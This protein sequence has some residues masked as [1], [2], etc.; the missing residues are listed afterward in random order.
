MTPE[1]RLNDMAKELGAQLYIWLDYPLGKAIISLL[2]AWNNSLHSPYLVDQLLAAIPIFCIIDFFAG[3]IKAL[4]RNQW[5]LRQAL[6][7][8]ARISIMGAL[9]V[10]AALAALLFGQWLLIAWLSGW[11]LT[12]II[13]IL[14]NVT[15][16]FPEDSKFRMIGPFLAFFKKK[17]PQALERVEKETENK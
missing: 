12:E 5:T 14:E 10:V 11:A 4:I 16:T 2:L 7:G 1:G 6:V 15:E 17:L 8:I 9:T 3:T 13:S